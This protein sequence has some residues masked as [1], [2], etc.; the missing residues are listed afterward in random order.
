M[1]INI[2]KHNDTKV[3]A[4]LSDKLLSADTIKKEINARINSPQD[5]KGMKK[6]KIF[7]LKMLLFLII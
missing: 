6:T 2:K 4:T 3:P 5:Y 1:N 7:K